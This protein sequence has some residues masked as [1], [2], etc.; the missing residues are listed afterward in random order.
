MNP[1]LIVGAVVAALSV[2]GAGLA[3]L[4]PEPDHVYDCQPTHD[5]AVAEIERKHPG[6]TLVAS[7]P[8]GSYG[9]VET[10][11]SRQTGTGAVILVFEDGGAACIEHDLDMVQ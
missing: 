6:A 5:A 9:R 10:Y 1:N 3:L 4:K 7:G 11:G 2:L 8:W